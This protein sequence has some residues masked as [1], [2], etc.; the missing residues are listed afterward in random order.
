MRRPAVAGR[1][2]PPHEDTSAEGVR[3]GKTARPDSVWGNTFVDTDEEGDVS[4]NGLQLKHV[5]AGKTTILPFRVDQGRV[6]SCGRTAVVTDPPA[7][8]LDAM[9]APQNR[10]L[11]PGDH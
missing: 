2:G 11:A 8:L 1:R 7:A 5:A 10:K 4:T 3:T 9:E 6:D